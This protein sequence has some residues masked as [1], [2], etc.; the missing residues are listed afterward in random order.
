MLLHSAQPLERSGDDD[1]LIMI[2]SP[3]EI[4]ELQMDH[5]VDALTDLLFDDFCFD[6]VSLLGR[7]GYRINAEA[8]RPHIF[9]QRSLGLRGSAGIEADGLE[10]CVHVAS[11]GA[12]LIVREAGLGTEEREGGE[13]M[14]GLVK[15]LE[16]LIVADITHGADHDVGIDLAKLIHPIA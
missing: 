14:E 4:A 5:S 7:A 11:E 15:R 9:C 12:L 1:G 16:R 13:L 2:L 6:H 8:K 10:P 3:R